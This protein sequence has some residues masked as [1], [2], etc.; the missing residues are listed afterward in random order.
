MI[1]GYERRLRRSSGQLTWE[2]SSA[3][4]SWRLSNALSRSS[5]AEFDPITVPAVHTTCTS[6][7]P[8]SSSWRNLGDTIRLSIS[9]ILQPWRILG[10]TKGQRRTDKY[11]YR[12]NRKGPY[13]QSSWIP[14]IPI[15]GRYI[16]ATTSSYRIFLQ[17]PWAWILSS[18]Y[19]KPVALHH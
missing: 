8:K 13:S 2:V 10:A 5:R 4:S 15:G 6:R 9:P 14:S 12:R 17:K 19:F 1:V 7:S 3:I 18:E 11:Q 16:D